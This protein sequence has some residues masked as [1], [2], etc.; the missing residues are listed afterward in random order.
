MCAGG[1]ET[2]GPD[3]YKV[4]RASTAPSFTLKSR[5]AFGKPFLTPSPAA[6]SPGRLDY[7]IK[8]KSPAFSLGKRLTYKP[9]EF[10][11]PGPGAYETAFT[12]VES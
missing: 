2:P 5:T 7:T 3:H 12:F 8:P 4:Q 11:T 10:G 6:Y 1:T 9:G